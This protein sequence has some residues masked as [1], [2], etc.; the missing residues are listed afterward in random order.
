MNQNVRR[1]AKGVRSME[2]PHKKL[3]VWQGAM[4]AAQIVYNLTK[5]FPEEERFGLISQMRRA[6]V[7]IPSN[8][9]EGA[10]RQGRREFRKFLSMAQ[11][12]L[13]ELDTQ[14]EL[15]VLLGFVNNANLDEITGQLLRIDKM[16]SGLIR[17]IRKKDENNKEKKV[18]NQKRSH[19]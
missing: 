19:T 4:K 13:S 17:S 1:K 12:S 3:D 2:K 11:G 8:I 7:S 6:A 16:L 5:T 18:P 9:A 15:A 10:A 14:L